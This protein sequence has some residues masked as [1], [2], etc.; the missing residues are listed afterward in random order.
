[1]ASSGGVASSA[2]AA[3]DQ[4]PG[5]GRDRAASAPPPDD[6]AAPLLSRLHYLFRLALPAV[7]GVGA[8]YL[9][10]KQRALGL[11]MDSAESPLS[12]QDAAWSGIVAGRNRAQGSLGNAIVDQLD[13]LPASAA[14][15]ANICGRLG[16]DGEE[17][18]GGANRK[19]TEMRRIFASAGPD[20]DDNVTQAA[21][22]AVLPPHLRM[23]LTD[24]AFA[25]MDEDGNGTF[26][27]DEV[28]SLLARC[29]D[30]KNVRKM[31]VLFEHIDADG[32]GE[33]TAA[34]LQS[35][36]PHVTKEQ[37]SQ[38]MVEFDA[39]HDGL[40][41]W[42]EVQGIYPRLKELGA[43]N[44]R[45][46]YCSAL[47]SPVEM[48]KSTSMEMA[49]Y[50]LGLRFM[51]AMFVGF[52]C[53]AVILILCNIVINDTLLRTKYAVGGA[54]L[55][56]NRSNGAEQD[57]VLGATTSLYWLSYTSTFPSVF[58]ASFSYAS[59]WRRVDEFNIGDRAWAGLATAEVIHTVTVTV[60]LSVLVWG[61][62][63][64]ADRIRAA[65]ERLDK[66][67]ITC[68]DFTVEVQCVPPSATASQLAMLF[69]QWGPIAKVVVHFPIKSELTNVLEKAS[70]A[71][72]ELRF[73]ERR[74]KKL[75]KIES[76]T[77]PLSGNREG[78][79]DGAPEEGGV[80]VGGSDAAAPATPA[81]PKSPTPGRR[82]VAETEAL[83]QTAKMLRRRDKSLR[84][85]VVDE[86]ATILEETLDETKRLI[87][88]AHIKHTPLTNPPTPLATAFVSFV[89]EADREK[90]EASFQKRTAINWAFFL[91]GRCQ[92]CFCCFCVPDPD[93]P[94]SIAR[95]EMVT[96]RRGNPFLV[97]HRWESFLRRTP[98]HWQ[99]EWDSW[100]G[101]RAKGALARPREHG[102]E[103]PF[104]RPGTDH[105]H[106]DALRSELEGA[107]ASLNGFANTYSRWGTLRHVAALQ[108]RS[109]LG[110]TLH[111]QRAPEPGDIRWENLHVATCS[112]VLRYMILIG[113]LTLF[114]IL[115]RTST[116]PHALAPPR[117]RCSH[118]PRP[119]SSTTYISSAHRSPFFLRFTSSSPAL[120]SPI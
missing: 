49:Q 26:S 9:F 112:K 71:I 114:C 95:R 23:H 41:T 25:A 100:L 84:T 73:V 38:L 62:G 59:F 119:H 12:A 115:V 106:V 27:F 48:L 16:V 11:A 92:C 116:R 58:L 93:A 20:S 18:E 89:V 81:T 40:F 104:L 109:L 34:E 55:A 5:G 29:H 37:M 1:M 72:M 4:A 31:R 74:R 103:H 67:V 105:G 101:D 57:A 85:I 94:E 117:A 78:A 102:S 46:P 50:F 75:L 19:Y 52:A 113:V 10:E 111:L 108:L 15:T 43:E 54:E 91:F 80:Y 24:E 107:D 88:N 28:S 6:A 30:E 8:N 42:D 61:L 53:F 86:L 36:L 87:A 45:I 14:H 47:C 76:M 68:S 2:G 97:D 13:Y 51:A 70:D 99:V 64:L 21:L 77:S 83:L 56:S 60:L 69:R 22:T 17:E 32:S 44:L 120:V 33:I 118:P 82:S 98:I 96:Q 39:N 90:C 110:I 79:L 35:I 63:A 66:G 65:E 3:A 7:F